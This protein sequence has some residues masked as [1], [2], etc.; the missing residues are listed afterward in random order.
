MDHNA[1]STGT[2]SQ[3]GDG[4]AVADTSGAI[5][6]FGVA[7]DKAATLPKLGS[8]AIPR[9]RAS[10]SLIERQVSLHFQYFLLGRVELYHNYCLTHYYT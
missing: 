10:P 7:P 4:G 1:D 8:G 6:P 2:K 3:A 5:V 9:P